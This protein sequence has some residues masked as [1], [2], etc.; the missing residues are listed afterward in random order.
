MGVVDM[1]GD[2]S[3]AGESHRRRLP[4]RA[5]VLLAVVSATV[6][7]LAPA[8]AAPGGQVHY[9]DLRTEPP[10]ELSM[11]VSGDGSRRLLRFANKVYNAGDGPL[12][13]EPSDDASTL[14]VEVVQRL[15]AHDGRGV[16]SVAEEREAGTFSFHSTHDHWHFDQFARYELRTAGSDGSIGGVVLTSEKITYCLID[17]YTTTLSLEHTASTAGYTTCDSQDSTQGI[18]VGWGDRY[19]P[20]LAGQHLDVSDVPDGVYWLVSTV[21]HEDLLAEKDDANNRAAT[22]LR[23][24]GSTVTVLGTDAPGSTAGI[25]ASPTSVDFGGQRVGTTSR[26]R[27][28]TVSSTGTSDLVVASSSITG[29]NASDFRITF[30]SCSGAIV[31]PG[32]TCQLRVTF[33][34]PFLA[35]LGSTRTATLTIQSNAS[36]VS[37]PLRGASSLL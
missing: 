32:A 37:V 4:V 20:G 2:G 30:N 33:S 25:G 31:A 22:R 36:S 8:A 19:A 24:S 15:Y 17:N 28:V 3:V 7:G 1:H 10:S 13:L 18:S 23:I 29:T 11:S 14:G 12:E 35:L 16:W 27:T 5:T 9:P 6:G 21:D 26:E 34:P